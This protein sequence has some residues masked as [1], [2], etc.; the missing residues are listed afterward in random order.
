MLR[1]IPVG[2]VLLF[3][4]FPVTQWAFAADPVTHPALD[5][6]EDYSRAIRL[7]SGKFRQA[8]SS[9]QIDASGAKLDAGLRYLLNRH[10][11][12]AL[13]DSTAA[14]PPAGVFPMPRLRDNNRVQVY[15]AVADVGPG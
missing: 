11:A 14:S 2:F 6:L 13:P 5:G 10:L 4:G 7:G 1:F 3:A 8:K 15:V 9:G 12:K